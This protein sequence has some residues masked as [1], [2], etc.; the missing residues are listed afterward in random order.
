MQ[1][2]PQ[3]SAHRHRTY[4]ERLRRL[5]FALLA[6]WFLATFLI[7]FF[8]RELSG[9]MVFGWPFSFYMAAHGLPLM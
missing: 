6:L 3:K 9:I 1:H 4:W 8:A 5:T 2:A 7:I